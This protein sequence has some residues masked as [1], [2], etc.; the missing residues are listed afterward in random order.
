VFPTQSRAPDGLKRSLYND[1]VETGFQSCA[2]FRGVI[3]V[4][5]QLSLRK[6]VS[7]FLRHSQLEMAIVSPRV[8]ILLLVMLQ[9]FSLNYGQNEGQIRVIRK[10]SFFIRRA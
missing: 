4:S 5:F 2:S 7:G 3:V 1:F 6:V 8:T 10:S 9:E